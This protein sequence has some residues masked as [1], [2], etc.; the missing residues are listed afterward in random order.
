MFYMSLSPG[1]RGAWIFP[2][3]PQDSWPDRMGKGRILHQ[4][5]RTWHQRGSEQRQ[6]PSTGQT[7]AASSQQAAGSQN[8]ASEALAASREGF[9]ICATLLAF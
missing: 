9:V 1:S 3:P 4:P 7:P 5:C 8:A 2:S 6:A